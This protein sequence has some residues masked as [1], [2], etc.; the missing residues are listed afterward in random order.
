MPPGTGSI[1]FFGRHGYDECYGTG[2][3][4]GDPTNSNKGYHA[5]PYIHKVFA[6]DANDLFAVR[7]GQ[8]EPWEVKPYATWQLRDINDDGA[9]TVTGIAYDAERGRLFVTANYYS[10]PRVHVY[11]IN[12]PE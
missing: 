9:A 11:K 7:Q 6:Y 10:S 2:E 8:M 4:C 1:L 12:L 5:Y 3:E